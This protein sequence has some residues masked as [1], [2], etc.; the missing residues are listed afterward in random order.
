M[1][2]FLPH[3][4]AFCFN[5]LSVS[6]TG[7][8]PH[9]QAFCFN[10]RSASTTGFLLQLQAFCFNRRSASTTGFSLTRKVALPPN[11]LKQIDKT[12]AKCCCSNGAWF[13]YLISLPRKCH[14]IFI[15]TS[16]TSIG[17]SRVSM[18]DNYNS[19]VV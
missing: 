9:L 19:V 4:Q 7:F 8:L 2:G 16:N 12:A 13:N 15:D 6:T 3:L 14:A 11:N 18:L 17:N 5:R 1:T 10:R